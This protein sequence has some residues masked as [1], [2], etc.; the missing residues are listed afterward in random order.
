MNQKQNNRWLTV[1]AGVCIQLCSG[2][3]YIWGVFREDLKAHLKWQDTDAM[4]AFSLLLAMLTFGCMFGGLIAKKFSPRVAV[5]AGGIVMG[6]GFIL[7]SFAQANCFYFVWIGYGL[8]GGFGSGMAYTN[9]IAV[10]QKWFPDKRGL[11]TGIII[12]GLGFSGLIFTPIMS[13]IVNKIG[14]LGA[15]TWIGVAIILI[16]VIGSIFMVNPPQN[17]VPK[18]W[19]PKESKEITKK[20][21]T[22]GEAF[23][24]PQMYLVILAFMLASAAG[25][26]LIPNAKVLAIKGGMTPA[27]AVIGVAIVS[28]FNALGRLVWGRVTD[29][30][31]CKKTLMILMVAACISIF[32]VAF[33]TSYW[34]LAIIA[35]VGFIYGGFLGV[36]PVLS[37][38]YFGTKH[39]GQI[40]GMVMFG[41]SAGAVIFSY[42]AGYFSQIG[43]LKIAFFIAAAA[44]LVGLLIIAVLKPPKVKE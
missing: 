15:F 2:I 6:L 3:A 7:A 18:G 33:I 23:K 11:I 39:G 21:F 30:I 26:M 12:S 9:V 43:N 22:P 19:T 16:S 27:N 34:V 35:V 5:A 42:T 31:G 14:A 13:N 1:V 17:F 37:A 10:T 36:F 38:D 32:P 8:L 40:Y 20:S 25:F 24:T 4:L 28:L 41:F 44:A 29:K